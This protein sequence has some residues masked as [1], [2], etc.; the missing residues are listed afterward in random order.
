MENLD[1]ALPEAAYLLNFSYE[2][3]NPFYCLRHLELSYFL[4]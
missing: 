2:L 3:I 4:C 1:Q